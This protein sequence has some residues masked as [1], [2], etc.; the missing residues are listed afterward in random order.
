METMNINPKELEI[1]MPISEQNVVQKMESM[2]NV[3]MIQPV[4]VWLSGLRIIDGFHRVEA[5]KRLKWESVI[6]NVID[7]DEEGFW[8]ARIQSARQH[9][10]IEDDRFRMWMV[11]CWKASKWGQSWFQAGKEANLQIVEALWRVDQKVGVDAEKISNATHELAEWLVTKARRWGKSFFE[12]R[13]FFY[14]DYLPSKRGREIAREALR[15]EYTTLVDFI[16]TSKEVGSVRTRLGQGRRRSEPTPELVREWKAA[17]TGDGLE[18]YIAKKERAKEQADEEEFRR[19]RDEKEAK[20]RAW[21][22]SP[23]GQKR[24]RDDLRREIMRRYD[25]LNEYVHK[26]AVRQRLISMTDGP[27]LIGAQA[28]WA[29]ELIAEYW[30]EAVA[31]VPDVNPLYAENLRLRQQLAEEHEKRIAAEFE[32]IAENKKE[33]RQRK[34]RERLPEVYA[35]A[36][37]SFSSAKA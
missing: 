26:D 2:Q 11:N 21:L 29:M 4:T 27:E 17:N 10:D 7:C 28:H 20:R 34:L 8:D 5:A 18:S 36:S 19:A 12:L 3:G 35:W 25:E 31:D 6:C 13:D 14:D 37:S 1:D 15:E 22:V 33:E 16:D 32:L 24:L 30:P 23:E 9:V